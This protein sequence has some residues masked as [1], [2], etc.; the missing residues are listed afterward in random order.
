MFAFHW[1]DYFRKWSDCLL[2]VLKHAVISAP[3]LPE[4][5]PDLALNRSLVS[6]PAD[7]RPPAG[8]DPLILQ[9]IHSLLEALNCL[10]VEPHPVSVCVWERLGER[11]TL[12][13]LVSSSSKEPMSKASAA[14][15]SPLG[16][17]KGG[18]YC[19]RREGGRVETTQSSEQCHK[20]PCLSEKEV[21]KHM[22]RD[23]QHC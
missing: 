4:S 9:E 15:T 6:R 1:R 3:A 17:I 10:A 20:E 18:E 22:D 21:K 14:F 8:K 12:M 7:T 23:W 2:C 5:S 11:L 19:R 16:G 13:P